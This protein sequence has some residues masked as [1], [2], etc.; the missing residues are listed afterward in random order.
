MPHRPDPDEDPSEEDMERFG[1]DSW[2]EEPHR[3]G[4]AAALGKRGRVLLVVVLV[5]LLSGIL[6]LARCR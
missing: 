4:P 3:Q 1:G 2:D 5:G 6:A